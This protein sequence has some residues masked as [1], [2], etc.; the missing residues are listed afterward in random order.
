MPTSTI[1]NFPDELYQQ[2]TSPADGSTGSRKRKRPS[3][4]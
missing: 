3:M 1:K 4:Q 2:M